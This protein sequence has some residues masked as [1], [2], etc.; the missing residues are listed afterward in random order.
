MEAILDHRYAF[1]DFFHVTRFPNLVPDREAWEHFLPRFKGYDYDHPAKYL[2]AFMNVCV[3]WELFM[4][5]F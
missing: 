5:M 4:K 3:S 2:L 1:Y